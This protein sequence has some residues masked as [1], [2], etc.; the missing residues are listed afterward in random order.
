MTRQQ[1]REGERDILPCFARLLYDLQ[2]DLALFTREG[3]S[4]PQ[5][6]EPVHLSIEGLRVQSDFVSGAPVT[7]VHNIP[8]GE[9]R[10]EIGR[11]TGVAENITTRIARQ[12]QDRIPA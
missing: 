2:L 6:V 12:V 5:C 4:H 9:R 8:T 7:V 1:S 3:H 10:A 11:M